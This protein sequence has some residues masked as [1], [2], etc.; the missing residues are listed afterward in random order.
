VIVGGCS[1]RAVAGERR[2]RHRGSTAAEARSLARGKAWLSSVQRTELQCD[3]E[4]VL[5]VAIG[6]ESRRRHELGRD[7]LAAAVGART[8]ASLRIGLSNKRE[9]KL[10][11]VL[12]YAGSACVGGASS[13][14]VEFTVAT[15]MADG[16][17]LGVARGEA[18]RLL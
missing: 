11:G 3:L 1:A 13:W 17:G 12:E 10:Q 15:P 7:C 2:R 5:R 8:P 6:L 9:G 18:S 16:G 14:R 4:E